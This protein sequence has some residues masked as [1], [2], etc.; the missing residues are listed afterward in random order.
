MNDTLIRMQ[1]AGFTVK[2]DGDGFTVKPSHLLTSKQRDFLKSN[3]AQIMDALLTTVVYKP[4][5]SGL[6]DSTQS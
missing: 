6:A 3:K 2:L 1:K 5:G 4:A